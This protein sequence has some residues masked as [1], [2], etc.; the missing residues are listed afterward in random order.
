LSIWGEH[1]TLKRSAR[2]I[3]LFLIMECL[4]MAQIAFL[5]SENAGPEIYFLKI[6]FICV[7]FIDI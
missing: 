4:S 5:D 1:E 7:Y 2:F 6:A 3:S